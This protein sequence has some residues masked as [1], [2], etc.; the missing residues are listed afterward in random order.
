MI[1]DGLFYS[2]MHNVLWHVSGMY[3]A[4]KSVCIIQTEPKCRSFY[5]SKYTKKKLYIN[6]CI[7]N[8]EIFSATR[9]M[10]SNTSS[11]SSASTGEGPLLLFI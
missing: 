6:V 2:S 8:M 1:N 11:I 10:K 4:H 9:N 5:G 3:V 7:L